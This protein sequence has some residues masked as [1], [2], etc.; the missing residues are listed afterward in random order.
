MRY[1]DIAIIGGGLAGST[2]AAMLGRAGISTVLIDPHESYPTDFRVEKLSGQE[3]VGRFLKTGIAESVLRRATFTGENWI[4]RFGRLLDKAPSRQFNILYDSLVNAVRDEIPAS[5][6]RICAKAIAVE[7]SEER[8]RVVLSN[9]ETISARLVVLANGLNVGLRHQ[10]GIARK[11][12]SACHSISIGF[13]IVPVGRSAFAFPALTYFSERPS[14]RIPYI[15][16]FPVGT[17][18]RAN[19]FV[20]RACD[21]PWLRELR[22]APTETLD[23]ALPR[24][25]AVT[26]PF[27]IP[28]E[29]KI[30]PVDL[31][32][33]DCRGQPGLVLVG[34]AFATSCPVAGTGCDKVFT[35]VERLCNVHIPAWL[36]CDGMSAAK[37]AAFYADPVKRACDEW[38]AAKAFDF[39][40]VSIGTSPYWTAQRWARFIAWSAQGLLRPLGGA[41]E[42]EPNLLGHSSSSSSSSASSRSSSSS[43]SLPSSA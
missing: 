42:L 3:Q 7:T 43:S 26:G 16:L 32:V 18:M 17:R 39:R 30:R 27:E 24:L 9:D 21:D 31:Y 22:R 25:E 15:T 29:I 12:I 1:T 33:N 2:A 37:I 14:D 19:L 28:G 10:L 23:A 11:V 34:D 4:A 41:F 20:Y 8:Q 13:D 35:D 36:A 38:S 40:S 5:V 6:E